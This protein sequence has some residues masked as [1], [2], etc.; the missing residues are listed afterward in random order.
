MRRT[1]GPLLP[2]LELLFR[3][4]IVVSIGRGPP[5]PVE[6]D[7]DSCSGCR[8]PGSPRNDAPFLPSGFSGNLS[9]QDTR[10][11]PHQAIPDADP[12]PTDPPPPSLPHF[13]K[14]RG[15]PRWIIRLYF[16][17]GRRGGTSPEILPSFPRLS[18]RPPPW[19]MIRFSSHRNQTKDPFFLLDGLNRRPA[20]QSSRL[21]PFLS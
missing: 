20:R 17:N 5:P 16:G 19:S 2:V 11:A 10:A 12:F 18:P 4:Q 15:P 1:I 3:H 9:G 6:V 7:H 14:D 8:F 21:I 13:F